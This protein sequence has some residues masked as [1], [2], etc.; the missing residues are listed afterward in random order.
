[1][2]S[3]IHRVLALESS[4][5]DSSVAIVRQGGFVEGCLSQSQDVAHAPFGGVVPE[6]ASRWHTENLLPLVERIFS[7]TKLGWSDIDGIAVTTRPGLVGSLLVGVVTAKSLA[8]ALGKPWIGVNHIEGHILSVLLNDASYQPAAKFP[9]LSLV[10][11]GGHT[12]LFLVE[13]IGRY[14]LLGQTVDDAAGEAFDKFAKLIGLGFPGG[15]AVDQTAK[16]GNVAAFRFPRG[17]VHE[18][19][20]DFSF[21]GLKASAQ[22]MLSEMPDP[23]I[24]KQKTD[25]CA[26]YQEAIVDVLLAKLQRAVDQTGVTQICVVGGVSANSRLRERGMTL[27]EERGWSWH[28]PPLRYCTDNAAMIALVGLHRLNAGERSLMDQGPMPRSD[29]GDFL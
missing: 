6:V 13:T 10:V 25:L 14:R 3:I 28:V 16:G 8:L 5:D 7:Q 9:F 21:S 22:R 1:M 27:S 11:S 4:C 20:L 2:A 23:E 19:N 15:I 26:S 17:M 18:N 29:A 24:Q 12:H